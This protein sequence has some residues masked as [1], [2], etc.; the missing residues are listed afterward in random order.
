[1]RPAAALGVLEAIALAAGF[2]HQPAVGMQWRQVF[3]YCR[4][5]PF[6]RWVAIDV[7]DLHERIEGLRALLTSSLHGNIELRIDV[8]ADI[9]TIEVDP[10]EL[11]LALVNIAV[12]ARDAMPKGGTLTITA[13]NVVMEPDYPEAT[14]RGRW[15]RLSCWTATSVLSPAWWPRAGG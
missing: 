5:V 10:G 2:E 8:P 4:R 11:E 12:N 9:W 15:R 1:M 3:E 14:Q 6:F 7:L 13:E